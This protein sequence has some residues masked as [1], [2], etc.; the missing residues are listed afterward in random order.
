[1]QRAHATPEG[2][3]RRVYGGRAGAG[4]ASGGERVRLPEDRGALSTIAGG[5][6]ERLM[7]GAVN[8]ASCRRCD[9][10]GEEFRWSRSGGGGGGEGNGGAR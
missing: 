3:V 1:M 9:P 10:G 8:Q 7:R 5:V 6:P 2:C 4:G